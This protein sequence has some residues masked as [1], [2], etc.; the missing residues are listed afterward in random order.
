VVVTASGCLVQSL[1]PDA[2]H[3]YRRRLPLS[4][5]YLEGCAI[6][7]T[8]YRHYERYP[9]APIVCRCR[10]NR[11][12][13]PGLAR[14]MPTQHPALPEC[15]GVASARRRRSRADQTRKRVPTGAA[16]RARRSLGTGGLD[17]LLESSRT[18][19]RYCSGPKYPLTP[20]N[21][22]PARRGRISTFRH[23][24]SCFV[25]VDV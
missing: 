23:A 3:H 8:H 25:F 22:N 16:R 24:P 21:T 13:V 17:A 9:R 19:A 10:P 14:R 7:S 11:R 6:R 1:D 5:P 2:H 18:I 20:A 15:R 12:G 4:M